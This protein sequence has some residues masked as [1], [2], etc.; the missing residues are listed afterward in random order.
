ME[1]GQNLYAFLLI[2]KWR[3]LISF[4]ATAIKFIDISL[5]KI[6]T[7]MQNVYKYL[8]LFNIEPFNAGFK[9]FQKCWQQNFFM[10]I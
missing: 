1:N 6:H 4:F 8:Y 9:N 7:Q 2:G 10:W 5:K 3:T